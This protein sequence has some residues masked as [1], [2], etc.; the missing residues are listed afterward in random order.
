MLVRSLEI[1][2][3]LE[4]ATHFVYGDKVVVYRFEFEFF[5]V[6]GEDGSELMQEGEQFGGV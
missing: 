6:F 3:E 4:S 5:E 2:T 1:K